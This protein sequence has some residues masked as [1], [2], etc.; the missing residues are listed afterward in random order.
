MYFRNHG[1]SD[2]RPLQ[3]EFVNQLPGGDGLGILENAARAR[4]SRLAFP[5]LGTEAVHAFGDDFGSSR[6]PLKNRAEGNVILKQRATPV[7]DVDFA[8]FAFMTQSY[9]LDSSCK[10]S[11]LIR[12]AS[13]IS[14]L[15]RLR[16]TALP[17]AFLDAVTPNL[18][19]NPLLSI[20][21]TVM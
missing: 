6:L 9:F 17:S 11:S 7:L 13:R 21:K 18:C 8:N 16:F 19:C 15:A 10:D 3:A 5:A 14:R 2:S 20:T 4:G 1:A 12:K